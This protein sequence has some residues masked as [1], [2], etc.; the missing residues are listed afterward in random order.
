MNSNHSVAP[1]L[2]VLAM[3]SFLVACGSSGSG[4]SFN[5]SPASTGTGGS[6]GTT[7]EDS[8]GAQS[9]SGADT[10]GAS[11][12]TASSGDGALGGT[13]GA[14]GDASGAGS[15]PDRNPGGAPA[16]TPCGDGG[17]DPEG[18][19]RPEL[20]ASGRCET[21]PGTIGPVCLD[22]C[23]ADGAPCE[24]ALDC[25]SLGCFDGSCG[26]G[27]C[28]VEGEDCREDA[29]CCSHICGPDGE[30]EID[31][32]NRECRPTGEDCSSGSGSG[33]CHACVEEGDRFFDML[34]GEER[35]GFPEDTCFAQGVGCISDDD[36]CRGECSE[37]VCR[38]PCVSDGDT[39]TSDGECCSGTCGNDG[40]C[41]PPGGDT[42][43]CTATGSRC[44]DHGE[45]CTDFC[46]G[47]FCEF[48]GPIN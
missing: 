27:L 24:R 9:S 48:V 7:S 44:V 46:F 18:S 10:G 21:M 12:G 28:I 37:G 39:C 41:E 14:A 30:C 26:G 2:V 17:D 13:A 33:C 35:C 5:G 11:S 34:G 32:P 40:A 45:C 1:S 6:G 36:C 42:P 20:C 43:E 47:G 19:A 31:E 8:S 22:A 15:T 23:F 3:G 29:E 25:C 4:G 16:G 38:T